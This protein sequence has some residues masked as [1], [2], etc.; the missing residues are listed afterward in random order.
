M[1]LNLEDKLLLKSFRRLVGGHK[2]IRKYFKNG[3]WVYIYDDNSR[4]GYSYVES[5]YGN[6]LEGKF[7]GKI[8]GDFSGRPHDAFQTLFKKQ[9]GQC[10]N[11]FEIELPVFDFVDGSWKLMKNSKTRKPYKAKTK[12]DLI[13]GKA[14][15][16]I[17]LEHIIEDHYII[18]D[19]FHSLDELQNELIKR[20]SELNYFDLDNLEA[21]PNYSGGNVGFV[22]MNSNKEK[23]VFA[24]Q[25]DFDEQGNLLV[26]HYILTSYDKNI[27][28]KLK[29]NSKEEQN[30]REGLLAKMKET[31]N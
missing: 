18:H 3:R 17:G 5:K 21:R 11:V 25:K 26:R 13:W 1:M 2:Y 15:R 30:L 4:N 12:I 31:P 22:I 19:D 6:T 14:N 9:G 7:G 20:I 24:L 16:N 23:F 28:E 29:E 10:L 27:P 8:W